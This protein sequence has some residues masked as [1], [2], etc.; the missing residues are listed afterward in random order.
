VKAVNPNPTAEPPKLGTAH[1]A[2]KNKSP[3]ERGTDSGAREDDPV[4]ARWGLSYLAQPRHYSTD[5]VL[6]SDATRLSAARSLYYAY[7]S[8]SLADWKSII[9]S[10][11]E[12][13]KLLSRR[14]LSCH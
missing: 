9:V 2:P 1:G 12:K 10:Q 8:L 11:P 14:H 5:K 7:C 13:K 6:A 3:S 4:T